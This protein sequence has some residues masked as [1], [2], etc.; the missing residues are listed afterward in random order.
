MLQTRRGLV[1]YQL[2]LILLGAAIL[3][4]LIFM[5]ANREE[6]VPAAP[7]ADSALVDTAPFPVPTTP[8]DTAD[9]TGTD[10]TTAA[11]TVPR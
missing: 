3:I 7:P 1:V 6:S 2:V 11:D 10:D 8:V 9:T 5:F 4:W